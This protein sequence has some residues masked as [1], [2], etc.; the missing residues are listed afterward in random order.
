MDQFLAFGEATIMLERGDIAGA[1]SAMERGTAIIEKSKFEFL[2]FQIDLLEAYIK[3]IRG[4]HAGSAQAFR[5]A[6]EKI[7]GTVHGGTVLG[8]NDLRLFVPTLYAE[9]AKSLVWSGALN[10]AEEVLDKGFRLD[11]S[12]P[13]LWVSKAHFQFA[14]GL[15]QLAQASAHYALAIW[16]DADPEYREY[17]SAR[18][19]QAEIR[20]TL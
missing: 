18:E 2:K 1:E 17:I 15:P 4:D 10:T 12:E 5:A 16:K 7:E 3:R 8:G 14:S 19:L 9:L 11:P 6:L 13:M 20:K